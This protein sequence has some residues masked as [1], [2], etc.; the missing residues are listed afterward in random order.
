MDP[1]YSAHKSFVYLLS[2]INNYINYVDMH[3]I[4]NY[5]IKSVRNV[6]QY[7]TSTILYVIL[8]I[9]QD[10]LLDHFGQ[11]WSQTLSHLCLFE[12][13]ANNF[14]TWEANNNK[15]SDQIS[16]TAWNDGIFNMLKAFAILETAG[17][18]R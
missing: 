7:Q 6:V 2:T 11:D 8:T 15:I 9:Y 16:I 13:Q 3:Q 14:Q 17:T 1:L 18:L 5:A 10:L 4:L 12:W